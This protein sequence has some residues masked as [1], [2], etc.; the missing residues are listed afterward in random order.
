MLNDS[1]CCFILF[2]GISLKS[3]PR[4]NPKRERFSH[5]LLNPF[6]PVS[7]LIHF[8][9]IRYNKTLSVLCRILVSLEHSSWFY[10]HEK[11]LENNLDSKMTFKRYYFFTTNYFYLLQTPR[12]SATNK[13]FR[14]ALGTHTTTIH[15]F[16]DFFPLMR[17]YLQQKQQFHKNLLGKGIPSLYGKLIGSE[18]LHFSKA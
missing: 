2:Y 16:C 14:G 9:R 7:K 5:L 8:D 13:V 10:C 11:H 17:D 6:F 15:Y 12:L 1:A 3:A 18:N 4:E